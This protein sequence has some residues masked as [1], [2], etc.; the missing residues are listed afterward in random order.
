MRCYIIFGR[1]G[2]EIPGLVSIIVR[3]TAA[4]QKSECELESPD[5]QV[6]EKLLKS[7]MT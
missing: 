5:M 3:I 2:R 1:D 6:K 7:W 4:T